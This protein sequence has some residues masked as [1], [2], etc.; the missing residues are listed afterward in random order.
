M[1]RRLAARLTILISVY[2]AVLVTFPFTLYQ[3]YAYLIP[4]FSQDAARRVDQDD[5]SRL[6]G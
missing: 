5:W 2:T 3:L 1:N 4:A 6:P